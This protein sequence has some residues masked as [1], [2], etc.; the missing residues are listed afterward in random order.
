[1]IF[2]KPSNIKI[3]KHKK[4]KNDKYKNIWNQLE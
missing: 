4:E 3:R 1:M 2:I